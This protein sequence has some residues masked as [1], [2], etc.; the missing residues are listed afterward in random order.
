[1]N[2]LLSFFII[3]VA[4]VNIVQAA[5]VDEAAARHVADKFFMEKS[6][7]LSVPVGQSAIRLAYIAEQQRFYVV[8]RGANGGYVVVA[9]DD[10]LPQVLGYGDAGDFSSPDLPPAVKYWLG[11]MDRQIAY[12][13][14]HDGVAVHR[15]TKRE[16]AVGPL[17]TT[18]WNQEEPFNNDCPTYTD[19]NG[20]TIRA[21]TGCVATATAQLMN[22][23]QWPPVGR[24]SHS[25]VYNVGGSTMTELS[26]DFSQSVYHWDL[27]LDEYDENSSAESCDAVARLMSDVGISMDMQYG[28]SSGAYEDDA[29]SALQRYFG[30]GDKYYWLRR[31]FFTADEWDQ[32]LVDEIGLRRPVMY[33]GNSNDSGHAF[34]LD[35]FDTD[36]FFH[37]NW[38]WGGR[39]DGFFLVSLLAPATGHNYQ[40]RQRGLFGLVPETQADVVDDVLHMRGFFYN[41]PS[42]PAPLGTRISMEVNNILEGNKMDTAGYEIWYD[43]EYYYTLIPIKLTLYDKNGVECKSE[44][45][46]SWNYMDLNVSWSSQY[47]DF[48]LPQSLEN[49]EYSFKV[50]YSID[51]GKNYDKTVLD[52]N[53]QEMM[54]KMVVRNDTAYLRDCF[55]YH[56]YGVESLV[57]PV[58]VKLGESF[59]ANVKLSNK[60]E[61]LSPGDQEYYPEYGPT[62]NVY[63]SLMKDGAEVAAGPMSE[64]M[65]PTNGANT[66]EMQVTAPYEPGL[67][68]LVLKDESGNHIMKLDGYQEAIGE[69]IVPVYVLPPCQRLVEDFESMTAN[70]STNDKDVQGLFTTWSFNKSGVHAPGEGRCNGTNAVMIKKAGYFYTSQPLSHNFFLAQAVLFNPTTSAAKYTLEYSIDSGATWE[71]AN[72][73]DGLS[74]AEVSANNV[75]TSLWELDLT[76]A[77]PALFR[78]AMTA[79][80]TASTYVDDVS[81]Y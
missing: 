14:T 3:A 34:V 35:G 17:L 12:L 10:R 2:K 38:G 11:E 70:N 1:M 65:V 42:S 24:G 48:D 44:L 9:G 29:S 53:G 6:S 20:N 69:V 60:A 45:Y 61:W 63:L 37:V 21:V 59:N 4:I 33:V 41:L 43:T 51:G 57:V 80:G 36:G 47:L 28:S 26:A 23:Y 67:Y 46:D 32:F 62:G 58:G 31:D 30:Y 18:L 25:Y 13:Q 39:Y 40:F 74:A 55:L 19:A 75:V 50:T 22:Y 71:K 68:E 15:P 72:T 76:V 49:G 54:C 73:Y 8:D 52:L 81:F 66:Y 64:V 27:M 56:I 5:Q 78:I 79:G 77:Q 7:R 16:T